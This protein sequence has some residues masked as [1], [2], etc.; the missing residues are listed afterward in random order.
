[1]RSKQNPNSTTE[2]APDIWDWV[3]LFWAP[4]PL[5]SS[6][7]SSLSST[8]HTASLAGLCQMHSMPASALRGH[9]M[10]LASSV[11]WGL[12]GNRDFLFTNGLPGLLCGDPNS[13][14]WY[15]A[16]ISLYDSFIPSNRVE[17]SYTLSSSTTSLKCD[18]FPL[19]H[20]FCV[21]TLRKYFPG[22]FTSNMLASY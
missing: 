8:A 20:S 21:E 14:T 12:Y 15:P 16:P 3:M 18:L 4:K 9:P 13:A 22:K 19:D 11:S 5:G 6:T 17:D 10:V 1:M 2:I 7:S